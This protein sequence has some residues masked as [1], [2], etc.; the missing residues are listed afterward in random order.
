[1]HTPSFRKVLGFAA[2]CLFTGNAAPA[3][4][5]SS[6]SYSASSP[7]QLL[8]ASGDFTLPDFDSSLGTLES[9]TLTLT[10]SN[11]AT[12]QVYNTTSTPENFINASLSEA[13]S[14]FGPG[15]TQLNTSLDVT[16]PSGT[17]SA[18]MNTYSTAAFSDVATNHIDSSNFSLW[19]DQ[20]G[21]V[22]DFSYDK[23][24]TTYQG[25]EVGSGNLLFGGKA[26]GSGEVTVEY[27]YLPGAGDPPLSTPEPRSMY[28]S[29]IAVAALVLCGFRRRNRSV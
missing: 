14:V 12:I 15:G 10:V 6:E 26:D 22:V 25:T 7:L 29:G 27:F 23:G 5:V 17:A 1:M 28:L 8:G 19:E 20:T 11:D 18:G 24:N 3:Q 21:G 9:I 2:L 16:L 13:G 4:A